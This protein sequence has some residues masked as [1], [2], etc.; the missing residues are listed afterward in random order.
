[1][2]GRPITPQYGSTRAAIHEDATRVEVVCLEM[3]LSSRCVY[4]KM[5]KSGQDQQNC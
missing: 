4:R 5:A 2:T 3:Q 1:M